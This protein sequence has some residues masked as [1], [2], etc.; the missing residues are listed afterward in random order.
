MTFGDDLLAARSVRLITMDRPGMG[1]SDPDPARTVASTA[2]DYRTFLSGVLGGDHAAVPVVANSQGALFGLAL[3]AHGWPSTLVLVSPADEVAHPDVRA[4]LPQAARTLPDLVAGDPGRARAVLHSFTAEGMRTMIL[5][6]S[7]PADR[8]VYT[9]PAFAR[10]WATALDQGF[11]HNGAGYVVDTMAAMA[12]WPLDL[13]RIACPTVVLYGAE[14]AGHSPDLC[15]L[16]AS[17]IL[18]SRRIVVPGAGGALL[19]T[20]ADRVLDLAL[21]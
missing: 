5:D 20:H 17:R 2:A 14:D 6:S 10:R 3:A 19:W 16:L 12:P 18:G 13:A 1:G 4:L 9:E 8:A 11:A 7:I 21:S 15:V